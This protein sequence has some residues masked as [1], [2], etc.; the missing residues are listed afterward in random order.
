MRWP[1]VYCLPPS[2]PEVVTLRNTTKGNYA[3]LKQDGPPTSSSSAFPL[4]GSEEYGTECSLPP[5][6]PVT[7][8]DGSER[9]LTV[10]ERGNGNSLH[11]QRRRPAN[12][13]GTFKGIIRQG[14]KFL[15]GLLHCSCVTVTACHYIPIN[16]VP[17]PL[18]QEETPSA[19]WL[20]Y[21]SWNPA[22]WGLKSTRALCAL[23]D[24]APRST[25]RA[26]GVPR[27]WQ[28]VQSTRMRL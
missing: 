12:S 14:R 1:G 10:T 28:S 27:A 25:K 8:K 2:Q 15:R 21:M 18:D 26:P 5:V 23:P 22:V 13:A 6:G 9:N 11:G 24:S 19:K 16:H 4:S 7:H 3:P 20:A 17:W